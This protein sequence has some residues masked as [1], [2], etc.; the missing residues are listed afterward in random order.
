M[1]SA[2]PYSKAHLGKFQK[3]PYGAEGGAASSSK[4][5]DEASTAVYGVPSGAGHANLMNSQV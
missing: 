1:T 4:F 2:L 3:D 5:Y